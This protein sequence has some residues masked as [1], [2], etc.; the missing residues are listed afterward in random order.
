MSRYKV[1]ITDYVWNSIQREEQ[2]LAEI[3]A[4]VIAAPKS[5]ENTLVDL[6]VDCDAIMTCF[7]QTTAKVI[8][9]SPKL[10]I[11]ARYGVGVDN[12]DVATATRLGI[13]V[14]NVPDYCMDEVSEHAFTLMLAVGRR[15]MLLDRDIRRGGWNLNVAKPV[16][17]IRGSTLGIVGFGRIGRMTGEKGR[18]FGMNLIAYDPLLPAADI[19]DRGA[20]PVD[21]DELLTRADYI[22][23]HAPLTPATHHLFDA[24]AFRK[25]KRTAVIVNTARGVLIDPEALAQALRDHWIGGAGIDVLSREP[26]E[27]G[28]PLIGLDNIVMTSHEAFYSEESLVELQTR[29]AQEVVRVLRGERPLN[30][31]NPEV[32]THTRANLA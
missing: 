8:E 10:K 9:A 28:N 11:V 25:M 22:S 5:D 30:L 21:F 1:L 17:R 18:A 29:T 7:A 27:K 12:I 6:A 23:I 24:R 14:T 4:E 31:A 19:R 13:V 3:G 16:H 26:P 15:I 32:A 2:V 20:E